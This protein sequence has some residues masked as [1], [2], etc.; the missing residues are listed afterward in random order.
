MILSNG[1]YQENSLFKYRFPI[2][3]NVRDI[4]YLL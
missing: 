4:R 2:A 1:E 3:E